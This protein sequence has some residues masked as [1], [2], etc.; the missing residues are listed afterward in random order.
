MRTLEADI[1]I[2]GG[3]ISAA[4]L[5]LK[6]TELRPGFN[7]RIVEAGKTCFNFKKRGEHRQRKID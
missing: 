6:L 5:S 1:D 4:M 7:I 3:G 2:V